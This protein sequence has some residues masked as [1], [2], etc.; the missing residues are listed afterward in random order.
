ML[1]IAIL[2]T[3]LVPTTAP[4][5]A[6]MDAEAFERYT[7]GKTLT[8]SANGLDYGA[9]EYRAGRRVRWAFLGGDCRAGR[10]FPRDDAICFVYDAPEGGLPQCWHFFEEGTGLRAVFLDDEDSPP[11]YET[12]SSDEPLV[13]L[14]PDVGV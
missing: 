10:W 2:L 3:L 11:L 6:P 14:G 8:Y 1:R 7:E 9:E 5:Q 12:R 13:C 4:A